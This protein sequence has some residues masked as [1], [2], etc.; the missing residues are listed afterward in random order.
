M[1]KQWEGAVFCMLD[2][3]R[4]LALCKTMVA[5]VD[6]VDFR[7]KNW[8]KMLVERVFP[9]VAK[10]GETVYVFGGYYRHSLQSS[11]ES[12]TER[13]WTALPSMNNVRFNFTA[14]VFRSQVYL[15]GVAYSSALEV[16]TPATLQFHCLSV[17][18]DGIWNNGVAFVDENE[19]LVICTVGG[20]VGRLNLPKE[21]VRF[22]V[23]LMIASSFALAQSYVRP[24]IVDRLVYWVNCSSGRLI[25]LHIDHLTASETPGILY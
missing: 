19:D 25:Q 10:V 21:E 13:V 4:A 8:P 20:R 11:C 24:V 23:D 3:R 14:V 2:R 1:G 5:E 17:P 6:L 18:G 22:R 7:V 12:V 15:P 9:G 16:F